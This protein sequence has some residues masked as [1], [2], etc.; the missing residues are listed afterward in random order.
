MKVTGHT[1]AHVFRR[2]DIG[3]VGTLRDRLERAQGY[4]RSLPATPKVTPLRRSGS[5]EQ[6]VA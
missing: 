2:Y 5:G 3:D 6:S 1:T 4:V